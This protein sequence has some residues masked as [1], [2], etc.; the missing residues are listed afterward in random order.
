MLVCV[1]EVQVRETAIHSIEAIIS[2]MSVEHVTKYF[3]PF[4]ERLSAKDGFI[5]RISASCLHHVVYNRMG[6]LDKKHIKSLFYKLCQDDTPMVL[7]LL[8]SLTH[9]FTHS[10]TRYSSIRY[11]EKQLKILVNLQ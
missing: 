3:V 10:L 4:L 5:S 7:T 9:T 11:V 8:Y 1:E 2:Q 6:E